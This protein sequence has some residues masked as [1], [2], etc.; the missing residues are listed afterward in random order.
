MSKSKIDVKVFLSGLCCFVFL[1]ALNA[2]SDN[3]GNGSTS[4]LN[5]ST[6]GEIQEMYTADKGCGYLTT[7][8]TC[9]KNKLWS[10]WGKACP[11][12]L[13]PSAPAKEL[14]TLS[15]SNA[16]NARYYDDH[17]EICGP[18][19]PKI[20]GFPY[21]ICPA[22]NICE[23]KT[24][25]YKCYQSYSPQYTKGDETY[26]TLGCSITWVELT[27]KENAIAKNICFSNGNIS[28]PSGGS[29]SIGGGGDDKGSNQPGYMLW[30]SG[31][32]ELSV[33]TC[34]ER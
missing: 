20:G 16:Q 30:Q 8:R 32:F 1:S 9:C 12:I 13:Y 22:S 15:C 26:G 27:M 10:E 29:G 2:A 18:F 21:P 7:K 24:V 4:S 11:T 34:E 14:V 3:S 5:C 28:G 33:I 19:P 17:E 31:K 23:G 6:V 25:G